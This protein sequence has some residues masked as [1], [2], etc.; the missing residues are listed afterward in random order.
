MGWHA[1]QFGLPLWFWEEVQ[2]L[3]WARIKLR[4]FNGLL[5]ENPIF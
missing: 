3:P 1:A 5:S 4:N 2:A